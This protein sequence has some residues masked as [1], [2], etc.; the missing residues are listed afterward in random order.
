MTALESSVAIAVV[1]VQLS[2]LPGVIADRGRQWRWRMRITERREETSLDV[3]A[4]TGAG[5][6]S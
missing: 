1:R 2:D 4:I 5:H 6:D 3:H